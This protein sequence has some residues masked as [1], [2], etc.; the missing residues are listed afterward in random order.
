MLPSSRRLAVTW[1]SVAMVGMGMVGSAEAGGSML[2]KLRPR[3]W[4]RVAKDESAATP[5]DTSSPSNV[6]DG[7]TLVWSR[8]SMAVDGKVGR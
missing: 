8:V 5:T 1:L 3:A 2:G 4:T 6:T 7:T